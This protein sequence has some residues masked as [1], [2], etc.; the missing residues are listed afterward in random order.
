MH[1]FNKMAGAEKS[2]LCSAS[3]VDVAQASPWCD[4]KEETL[5]EMWSQRNCLFDVSSRGY[6][7]RQLKRQS[8]QECS[9]VLE[10]AVDDISKKMTSL[11]TQYS[12][13]VKPLP[14][15]S[16]AKKKT[17]RQEWILKNLDFLAPHVK[18]RPSVS[19]LKIDSIQQ[20]AGED[21]EAEDN[22]SVAVVQ[23]DIPKPSANTPD[24]KKKK[25]KIEEDEFSVIK[26]LQKVLEEPEEDDDTVF[27]KYI[28]REM[29]KIQDERTKL[30]LRQ[31]FQTLIVEARMGELMP[32]QGPH[33][34][35]EM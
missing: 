15:G 29:K 28:T 30:L 22:T 12:R 6:S 1:I 23:D 2:E 11:R 7:N 13:L 10:I 9:S 4:E 5:V 14:S 27:A 17:P 21:D 24:N 35:S 3:A 25:R 31:K 26:S 8:I 33:A 34:F 16:G 18:A 20:D 32:Y 19:N